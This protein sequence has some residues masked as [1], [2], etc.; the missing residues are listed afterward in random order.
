[1]LFPMPLERMLDAQGRPYFLWD[2]D[3][4]LEQFLERLRDPDPVVRGYCTAKLLRQAR[5]DDALQFVTFAEI[6]ALWPFID[7]HLGREREFWTWLLARW[8]SLRRVAG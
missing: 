7:R 5:P 2:N 3:L 6:D 1:M 4:T 8:R